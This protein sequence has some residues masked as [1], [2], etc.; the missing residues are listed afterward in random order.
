MSEDQVWGIAHQMRART[1]PDDDLEEILPLLNG[2]PK[3]GREIS[4]TD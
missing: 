3:G 2:G 1:Y 4:G